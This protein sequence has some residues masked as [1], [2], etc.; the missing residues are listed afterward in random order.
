MDMLPGN[1]ARSAG[2]EKY[3]CISDLFGRRKAVTK[4]YLSLDTFFLFQPGQ[5]K[6]FSSQFLYKGVMTS[7]GTIAF[8]RIPYSNSSTAHSRVSAN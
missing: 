6:L 8:T 2:S 7:A 1:M 4:R 3:S 5:S